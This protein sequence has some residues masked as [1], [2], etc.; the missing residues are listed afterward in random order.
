MMSLQLLLCISF[1]A[2]AV[3]GLFRMLVGITGTDQLCC[4]NVVVFTLL[5]SRL[6][7]LLSYKMEE[8][9]K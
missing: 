3:A 2:E 4:V 1:D 5:C 7:L 6:H 9:A 8:K